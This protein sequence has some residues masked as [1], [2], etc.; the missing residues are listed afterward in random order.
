MQPGEYDDSGDE[1]VM[2]TV[3]MGEAVWRGNVGLVGE[4]RCPLEL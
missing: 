3:V 1:S 4:I 2:M